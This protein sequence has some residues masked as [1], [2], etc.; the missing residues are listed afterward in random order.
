MEYQL[1]IKLW[2]PSLTDESVVAG[3]EDALKAA[4]GDTVETEGYD[5]SPK[6]FNFFMLTADP[7]PTFRRAR[8][9]LEKLGIVA[10]V[11]AAYR[12]NGGAQFTSIWPLRS[13]RKFKLPS[14]T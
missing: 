1:I 11:S 7:K 5:T 8:D 2:R 12:L 3:M 9:A 6:E 13:M 4:L 14:S 10:G